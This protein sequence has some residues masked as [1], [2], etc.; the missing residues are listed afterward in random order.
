MV[1]ILER[2]KVR[3]VEKETKSSGRIGLGRK[4]DVEEKGGN[5]Q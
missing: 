5:R 2:R 4:G 3:E 1:L